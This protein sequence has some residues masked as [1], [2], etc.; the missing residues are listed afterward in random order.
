[1]ISNKQAYTKKKDK[2][3][4]NVLYRKEMILLAILPV[5]RAASNSTTTFTDTTKLGA[6][7]AAVTGIGTLA[8][9][10]SN[11]PNIWPQYEDYIAPNN[12]SL[13]GTPQI[14]WD[15]FSFPAGVT[16]YFS[17]AIP[18]DS[19]QDHVVVSS[20]FADNAHILY[21][22]EYDPTGTILVQSITPEDGL[23]DGSM[24]PT[25][26]VTTDTVAPYNWQTLRQ[27]SKIFTPVSV[28]NFIVLTIQVLNYNP[29]S[30]A[31]VAGV[32]FVAD[33]YQSTTI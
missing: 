23:N 10:I 14:I 5:Q 33:F 32:A 28:D 4:M 26:G 25:A 7:T 1:M 20:V 3:K 18:I 24:N 15:G 11:V 6:V 29:N 13:F 16:R 17:Q 9:A 12:A 30:P 19:L 8:T 21:I 31:N 2:H 22:E 27:Y